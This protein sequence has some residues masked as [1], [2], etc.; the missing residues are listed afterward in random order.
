ML[1]TSVHV[2]TGVAGVDIIILNLC[3][4]DRE[5]QKNIFP[6]NHFEKKDCATHSKHIDDIPLEEVISKS[7]YDIIN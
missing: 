6:T 3:C 4:N 5:Q 7:Q 2:C 1:L